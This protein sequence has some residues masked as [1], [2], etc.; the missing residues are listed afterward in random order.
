[1]KLRLVNEALAFLIEMVA[2]GLLAYWGVRIGGST[3]TRVALAVALPL[4]AAVLWGLFAAPRARFA[5]PLVPR[6]LVKAIVFGAA[7]AALATTGHPV[8]AAAFAA[9]ALVNTA[10]ATI[11]RARY[12]VPGTG[13]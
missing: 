1:M 8:W 11:W 7:T 10:S 2:L 13:R 3:V 5:V 4:A 6:L 12:G 9:V